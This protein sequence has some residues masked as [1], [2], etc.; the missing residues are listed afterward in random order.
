MTKN[1]YQNELRKR[2]FF[3]HLKGADGFTESSINKFAEAIGQW[4]VFSENEDFAN[5]D[6]VKAMAFVNWLKTRGSKTESG[7]ISLTTQ[8]NYLRHIKK[9]FNWLAD[10]PSYRSKII[11]SDIN[12]MRLSKKEIQI[13]TSGTNKKMPT[14]EEI[15]E[16]IENIK[17]KNEIDNR[18][19]AM[20]S[21]ALLTGIRVSALITLRMKNFDKKEKTIDQNPN[22]G[23]KTKNSKRILT[24]FFPIGWD[25]PEQY[26]MEW[27]EYLESKGFQSDDPIFPSTLNDFGVND[28]N[29][30]KE[31]ISKEFW[32]GTGGVRKILEKR[33]KN[34]GLPYFHPHLFR[35]SIVSILSKMRLT[36]EDKKAISLN[37][38]HANIGTTFGS[39]G[40]GSMSDMKAVEIV[41]KLKDFQNDSKDKLTLSDSERIVLEGVLKRSL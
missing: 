25:G 17:V 15:K 8:Y 5:F 20:I 6:K 39:Y 21:F 7:Q 26:F 22:D 3:E 32:S 18:D 11:K 33:C 10:Q 28:N 24:T 13:A 1:I 2:E 30:S 12:F 36:E 16:I 4:Q 34:A 29:Y 14:L 37:L 27:F 31:F 9:F 19:R 23:V 35:H 38:G 41:Q 40:Y